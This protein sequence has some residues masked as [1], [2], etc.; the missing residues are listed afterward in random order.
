MVRIKQFGREL[1]LLARPGQL[2]RAFRSTNAQIRRA[3]RKS[4][5]GKRPRRLRL[6]GAVSEPGLKTRI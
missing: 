6:G 3:L 2:G 1:A 4:L 5:G